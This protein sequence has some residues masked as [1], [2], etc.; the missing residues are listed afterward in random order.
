VSG[1]GRIRSAALAVVGAAL[2][3]LPSPV[4]AD[5]AGITTVRQS[6]ERGSQGA[7]RVPLAAPGWPRALRVLGP[8]AAHE[9]R[10]E[11][12]RSL[13]YFAHLTDAQ[14]ADEM[15]P[16]RLE[17][18]HGISRFGGSWRPH[19][20]LGPQ[21]FDQA[22]RNVNANSISPVPDGR[23][24]RARVAF[25]LV[26]GDLADNHQHNEVR[27]G[28]R[29]L[30]G[31]RIDP[32]SGRR[33]G[34]RNPCPGAP[35]SV[36]RRLNRAVARREYTGVQ[37]YDDWPGRPAA[38]Y[39]GF[40][41]PDSPWPGGRYSALP[42]YPGLLERAQRPFVASGLRTPWFAARGNH[43]G[44]AQGFFAG[45]RGAALATGCRKALPAPTGQAMAPGNPWNAMRRALRTGRFEWVP[46]DPAR[47]FVSPRDFKRLHGRADRAHGFGLVDAI[48]R[49]RSG[50]A[51]AYYDWAARPGVR[52]VSID[53]VSEAG[54]P[55]GNVDHPQ[56]RWL[57]RTLRAARARDEL[58]VVFGHHSLETMETGR[59]DEHV[60]G[61]GLGRLACDG[62][63]RRSSPVHKGLAGARSV[64]S[65]FLSFPNV[66]MFV[67]GHVHYNRVIPQVGSG[68]SGFWQVTT[69]SHMSFPQ[70]TRLIE[71]MDNGD[72]TLSIFGTA[73][74]TAAPVAAPAS[75]T[76]AA[77]LSESQLGSISRLLAANVRGTPAVGAASGDAFPADNVER[78]L[79]DPRAAR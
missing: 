79:P 71:L 14:L 35:R 2:L 47:R 42:S 26:T 59:P 72:G 65:L 78:V 25:A 41:D 36:V 15:S 29:I 56:Y 34:P 1:V 22:V 3:T 9:G 54:G 40:Y 38:S 33:I 37:D 61:C 77:G 5:P 50:G 10:A 63:P 49:R 4:R 18:L 44:L 28:V 48:E 74:D 20:P 43:D 68:G 6:I 12:R 73:L 69:A 62:D 27:W 19:E 58:V 23:G 53:T 51:A 24:R 60:A 16:A 31:G 55:D 75:G 17:Y 21:T 11:R 32:F 46:P 45:A 52:F 64:R 67:T 39:A 57:R 8:A 70:Q 66:V 13:V 76:P 30:E 7:L